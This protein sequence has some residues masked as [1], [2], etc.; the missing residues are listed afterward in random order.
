MLKVALTIAPA[1]VKLNYNKGTREII[2]AVNASLKG[3]GRVLIQLV[4]SVRHPLR[5]KSG[6]QSSAKAKYN[7]TKREC[8]GVLKALKKMKLQLYRVRFTLETDTNI[9]II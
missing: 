8:H 4:D 2:L 3:Q 5:Y 7:T 1:L 6:L 9:L